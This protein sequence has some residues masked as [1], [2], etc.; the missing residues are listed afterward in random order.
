M[1]EEREDCPQGQKGAERQILI[2]LDH[3]GSDETD[4]D[5]GAYQ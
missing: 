2:P 3:L 4:P 1:E 5:D